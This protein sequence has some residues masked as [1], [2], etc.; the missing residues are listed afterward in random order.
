MIGIVDDYSS[1]AWG[2]MLKRKKDQVPT[3][4]KFV[5]RMK[6]RGTP[7]KFIRCD[8]AGENKD[9][10]EK[11]MQSKDLNDI[12]FE[13]TPRDAPQYNGRIERKFAVI[14]SRMRVNFEAAKINKEFR[15]KLWGEACMAAIDVENALV[16]KSKDCLLYTSPSPRDQRGSRM[17]SSA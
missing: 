1:F 8:N 9:L 7:V 6:S 5:R 15:R 11:C 3:L 4:M 17:P 12:K 13:Y 16:S 2:N 10:Q 14:Y